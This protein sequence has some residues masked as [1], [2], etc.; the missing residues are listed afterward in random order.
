MS[1]RGP[2]HDD[3][4]VGGGLTAVS[5][6]VRIR[7]MLAT[8][9]KEQEAPT[10][11]VTGN[12]E[13]DYPKTLYQTPRGDD[14]KKNEGRARMTFDWVFKPE[15]SQDAVYTQIRPLIA[16]VL[17]GYNGTVLAYGQTNSGKTYTM[18]GTEEN[19]GILRRMFEQFFEHQRTDL[20]ETENDVDKEYLT[21]V[22]VLEVYNERI[23]DL[24][25]KSD[26]KYV[27]VRE[28]PDHGFFVKGLTKKIVTNQEHGIN[29]LKAS[30][31]ERTVA[32]TSRND[33]SSR[34]HLIITISMEKSTSI[35]TDGKKDNVVLVSKMNLVD[36][37]GSECLSQ[38][39]ISQSLMK[40]TKN[41]NTSLTCL[42]SVIKKLALT[43][44]YIPY[45]DSKLTMLLRDSLGGNSKT[46]MMATLSPCLANLAES[47]QT[48]R[49]ARRTKMIK[50]KPKITENPRDALLKQ[51]SQEVVLLKRQLAAQDA[52]LFSVFLGNSSPRF[53][54]G[55]TPRGI[56]RLSCS[57][58]LNE[59][60]QNLLRFQLDLRQKM[61]E[62][63]TGTVDINDMI[64]IRNTRIKK[65]MSFPNTKYEGP[66][67][68]HRNVNRTSKI[69]SYDDL[70]MPGK[71]KRKQRRRTRSLIEGAE[72]YQPT[73]SERNVNRSSSAGNLRPSMR[74]SARSS[75]NSLDPVTEAEERL[76]KDSSLSI[77]SESSASSF[78]AHVK[79][80][81]KEE[82]KLPEDKSM[83]MTQTETGTFGEKFVRLFE[84]G[85]LPQKR[86]I[87]V[88]DTLIGEIKKLK[89]RLESVKSEMEER[90]GSQL[91]SLMKSI[92]EMRERH[93][94][95]EK[96][97]KDQIKALKKD[98]L[99]TKNEKTRRHS[100]TKKQSETLKAAR[101]L[102]SKQE[103]ELLAERA[104]SE[105]L[106]AQIKDLTGQISYLKTKRINLTEE[107]RSISIP[108]VVDSTGGKSDA[109]TQSNELD[110][111]KV[112]EKNL[113]EHVEKL[114]Q[115]TI[116][117][118]PSSTGDSKDSYGK[119]GDTGQLLGNSMCSVI[120]SLKQDVLEAR[121]QKIELARK[122]SQEILRQTEIIRGL[123]ANINKL[124]DEIRVQ[125]S[126][127]EQ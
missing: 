80:Q 24:L 82:V 98:V 54:G 125:K 81:K 18:T 85:S 70:R 122:S 4:Q 23:R 17:R 93:H 86:A 14:R 96:S 43:E 74:E 35:Q 95:K 68:D 99:A 37:A 62:G 34:S 77:V 30:L 69:V 91:A 7:A 6:F 26:D 13:I 64:S 59:G 97:L 75:N 106:N 87:T 52:Q 71:K 127:K 73:K 48:L 76:E 22:C 123:Y 90:W 2:R 120:D 55:F 57:G 28:H 107:R 110:W 1:A 15:A 63:T 16:E 46:L 33:A 31:K 103:E 112:L 12:D 102:V 118:S 115:Q 47:I 45:R 56:R 3:T 61:R 41:I 109:E 116:L 94:G 126:S 92:E 51:L 50:N 89:D 83:T 5:V 49:Y 39:N 121:K 36:L 113:N 108:S 8:E 67:F 88:I 27:E 119:T 66:N 53:G 104:S 10:F 58:S 78:Q 38:D 20:E 11:R 60:D 72:P 101:L 105:K 84:S 124:H 40:E 114:C 117:A 44:T 9:Q 32:K 111:G 42:A 79:L 21:H 25:N 19:P 65:R 100:G 29:T